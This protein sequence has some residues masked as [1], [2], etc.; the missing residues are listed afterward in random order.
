MAAAILALTWDTGLKI[1]AMP[2]S[3]GTLEVNYRNGRSS[4]H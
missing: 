4:D 1:R 3:D 2:L